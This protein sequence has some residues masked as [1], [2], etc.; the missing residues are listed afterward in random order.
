MPNLHIKKYLVFFRLCIALSVLG[1]TSGCKSDKE[2]IVLSPDES[3]VALGAKID[4]LA[5]D[6]CTD[7]DFEIIGEGQGK[8]PTYIGIDPPSC[9]NSSVEKILSYSFGDDSIFEVDVADINGTV[10]RFEMRAVQEGWSRFSTTLKTSSGK[11][12]TAGGTYTVMAANRVELGVPCPT[13]DGTA[14]WIPADTE[15]AFDFKLFHDQQRLSGYDYYPFDT[16]GLTFVEGNGSQIIYCTPEA[17]RTLEVTAPIDP[18]FRLHLQIIHVSHFDELSV[19]SDEPTCY[20]Q[21]RA[22]ATA[23]GQSTCYDLFQ[24]EFSIETPDICGFYGTPSTTDATAL[25][26][27]E[28]TLKNINPG[29]CIVTARL[30]GSALTVTHELEFPECVHWNRMEADS[31]ERRGTLVDLWGSSPSDVYMV[32]GD[33]VWHSDA[34]AL[35]PILSHTTIGVWGSGPEDI[36][37]LGRDDDFWHGTVDATWEYHADTLVGPLDIWGSGPENIF[38]VGEDGMI[39]HSD[40]STFE[41]MESG[42]AT[43]LNAVWGSDAT[44]VFAVGEDGI[45]LHYDGILWNEMESGT[46]HSL[47]GVWGTDATDVFAVGQAGTMLHFDGAQWSPLESGTTRDLLDVWVSQSDGGNAVGSD[48]IILEYDGLEWRVTAHLFEPKLYAVWGDGPARFIVGEAGLVI[49][50]L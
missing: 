38:I 18:D 3:M 33:H 10:A 23:Q 32:G 9:A 7:S 28:I 42:T 30:N 41:A 14:L 5:V 4:I 16:E 31:P 22:E 25:G 36:Y 45:I 44:D 27:G 26:A 37:I 24:R 35:V 29:L 43:T 50:R 39:A 20:T 15:I 1:G 34:T 19:V 46:T 47:N 6:G 48:G 13:G 49:F 11:E 21:L 17:P 12:L 2:I 8:I 40:G